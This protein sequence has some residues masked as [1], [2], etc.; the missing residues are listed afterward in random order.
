[1]FTRLKSAVFIDSMVFEFTEQT[2]RSLRA[3]LID[4]LGIV[5]SSLE[6]DVPN[7]SRYY[8]WEGLNDL[9]YGIYTLEYSNGQ[10]AH[11]QRMVKR[12]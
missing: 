8:Q 9:P 4:E 10:E 2:A 7:G 6:A 1:M 11:S 3:V 5:C 12:I